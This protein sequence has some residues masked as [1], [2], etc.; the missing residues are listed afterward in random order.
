MHENTHKYFAKHCQF[1]YT[2]TGR[3][4]DLIIKGK[5]KSKICRQACMYPI[6]SEYTHPEYQNLKYQILLSSLK[7]TMKKEIYT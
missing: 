3:K 5:F 6:T 1:Q 7:I 4:N 2:I